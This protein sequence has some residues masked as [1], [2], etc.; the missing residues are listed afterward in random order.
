MRGI[1]RRE[2]ETDR[3]TDRQRGLSSQCVRHYSQRERETDGQTER[4]R[5]EFP[6]CAALFE[7]YCCRGERERE[8]E[9]EAQTQAQEPS[10]TQY[11]V[12]RSGGAGCDLHG[13]SCS[14]AHISGRSCGSAPTHAL[15]IRVGRDG[16]GRARASRTGTH[17]HMHLR[18]HAPTH[19]PAVKTGALSLIA[20]PRSAMAE[21]KLRAVARARA[22]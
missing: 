5:D 9:R 7:A 18:S 13:G 11:P 4:E 15:Y 14:R 8:R 19:A 21:A 20:Q 1:I 3:Q 2:R 17:A 10:N 16:R 22:R 12:L 6:V